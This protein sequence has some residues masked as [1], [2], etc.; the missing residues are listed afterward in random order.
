MSEMEFSISTRA[1]FDPVEL[2]LEPRDRDA[3]APRF[4][5][6][7]RRRSATWSE[8]AEERAP[9]RLEHFHRR[10]LARAWTDRERDVVADEPSDGRRQLDVTL[11]CC[12]RLGEPM[13]DRCVC[14]SIPDASEFLR[15][16]D[17]QNVLEFSRSLW[18]APDVA[19]AV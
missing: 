12:S 2:F 9:N 13:Q 15:P 18:L 8:R 3:G 5:D 17:S 14:A 19:V 16:D 7:A 11:F 1:E 10:D 6:R 4:I